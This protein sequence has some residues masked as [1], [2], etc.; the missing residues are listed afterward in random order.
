MPAN[1]TASQ[2]EITKR[3]IKRA[4]FEANR[5]IASVARKIRRSRTAV[6]IAINHGR[7]PIV[8]EKTLK[9]LR[10]K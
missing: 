9:E 10:I 3:R 8:L 4:L 7:F 6:S 1:P 5:S 2:H